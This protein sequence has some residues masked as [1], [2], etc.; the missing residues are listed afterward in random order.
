MSRGQPRAA[1]ATKRRQQVLGHEPLKRCTL[2]VNIDIAQ[3]RVLLPWSG[4]STTSEH[5][6]SFERYDS[7]V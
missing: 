5:G 1:V 6:C 2:S 7:D 3:L 4:V